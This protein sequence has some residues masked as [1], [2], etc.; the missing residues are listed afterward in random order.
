MEHSLI[1]YME[2]ALQGWGTEK[3][4]IYYREAAKY[5]KKR[6]IIGLLSAAL[7]YSYNDPRI[8]ELNEKLDIKIKYK[9]SNK[10][11]LVED[12]CTAFGDK[13]FVE[14][15]SYFKDNKKRNKLIERVNRK[16]AVKDPIVMRKQYRAKAYYYVEISSNDEELIEKIRYAIDHPIYPL[17]L[18]RKCCVGMIHVLDKG[19]SIE[20]FQNIL[21]E[22]F[23]NVFFTWRKF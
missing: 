22:H 17:Y 10:G 23:D 1:L 21:K 14:S 3:S 15:Y 8:E 13:S 9:Y 6:S 20:E 7:G 19:I 16:N 5:P 2:G 12:F 4:S 11:E 18:G